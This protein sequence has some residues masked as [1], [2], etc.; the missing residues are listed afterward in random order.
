MQCGL[1]EYRIE[2]KADRRQRSGE[3]H[4]CE[5]NKKRGKKSQKGSAK[6]DK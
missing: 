1:I 6:R 5:R 4:A 3:E 2:E